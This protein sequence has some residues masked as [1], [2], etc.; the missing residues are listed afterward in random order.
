MEPEALVFF[1]DEVWMMEFPVQGR[2]E[3]L[4]SHMIQV[5]P[6][7]SLFYDLRE[8]CERPWHTG[9]K[10]PDPATRVVFPFQLG[11]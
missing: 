2:T 9:S 4:P 10:R 8:L 11:R 1:H 5:G 7:S 6:E 3:R